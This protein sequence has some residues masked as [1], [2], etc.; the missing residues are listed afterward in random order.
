MR[1]VTIAI[2][3]ITPYSASIPIEDAFLKGES[4]DEH[5][6][7]RWREKAHVDD[8][9]VVFIPGVSFKMALDEVAGVLKEKIKGKGNSTWT[10]QFKTGVTAMSDLSLGI[11]IDD[12]KSIALY[13]NADG[14]R[15][16]GTRVWRY[17]PIIPTWRGALDMRVF[18]DTLSTEV[19]ERYFEQAGILAG[20]GRGRPIT[21][22]AAGNGRFRPVAFDW[23]DS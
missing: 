8:R 10:A 21:G 9:G 18:N 17:F 15:G 4:R 7:R 14:R 22:C 23:K 12:V 6:K 2:E 3:G 11:K 19:F 16:S 13:C 1:D 20:V 5:E